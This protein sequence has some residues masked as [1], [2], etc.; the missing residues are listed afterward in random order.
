VEE[1]RRRERLER[2]IAV[3]FLVLVIGVAVLRLLAAARVG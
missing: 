1:R 2:W 3:L